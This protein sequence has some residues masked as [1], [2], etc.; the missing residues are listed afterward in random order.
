MNESRSLIAVTDTSSNIVGEVGFYPIGET[1]CTRDAMLTDKL[2]TSQREM[3][4]LG[5]SA[6]R[7]SLRC[8]L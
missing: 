5:I 7:G 2:F 6:R 4:G 8:A 3:T 1:R